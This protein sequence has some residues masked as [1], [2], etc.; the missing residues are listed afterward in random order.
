[1]VTEKNSR[2]NVRLAEQQRQLL[3]DAAALTGT[4]MSEFLLAPA[5]ER[6]H[7]VLAA[8]R[9]TRI[10]TDGADDFLR[11]LDEPPLAI[12]EMKPL[13]EAEPIGQS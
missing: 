8:A 10:H 5:I 13:A 9:L 12:P 1:M 6:A 11:W 7:Q 4:S 2:L 3:K